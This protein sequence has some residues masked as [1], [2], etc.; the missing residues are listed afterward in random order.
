MHASPSGRGT[1]IGDALDTILDAAGVTP[2]IAVDP[3][4][5]RATDIAVGDAARLRGAT[6]WEPEIP[7]PDTL[8]ALVQDWQD[9]I[10]TP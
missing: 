4:R 9:R 7:F 3:E 1:R 8:R 2:E 5:F 10:G 6:G